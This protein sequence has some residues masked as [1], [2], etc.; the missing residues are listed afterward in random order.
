M[1]TRGLQFFFLM[2]NNKHWQGYGNWTLSTLLVLFVH[3]CLVMSDSVT[4]WTM[5][6]QAPLSMAF[7]RQHYWS[8]LPRPPP[9]NL[10]DPGVKPAF[11]ESPELQQILYP[12]SHLGSPYI[13]G[14]N[15]KW[16]SH[17]RK[18]FD[19]SSKVYQRIPIWFSNFTLKYK[20]KRKQDSDTCLQ[21]LI[22]A[23]FIVAK[24]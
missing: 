4:P 21:I 11:P 3:A 2:E 9:E 5:A 23:L 12:L 24:R 14:G 1:P 6:H 22:I 15:V 19:C 8:R 20:P 10:P 17:C 13:A 16:C 18:P 7:S